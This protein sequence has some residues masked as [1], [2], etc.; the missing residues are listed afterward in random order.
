MITG[1]LSLAKQK[2][3]LNSM[4][5]KSFQTKVSVLWCLFLKAVVMLAGT[6]C[7]EVDPII[8]SFTLKTQHNFLIKTLPRGQK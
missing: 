2:A 7:A 3:N 5:Q 4:N 8:I 6:T 1:G